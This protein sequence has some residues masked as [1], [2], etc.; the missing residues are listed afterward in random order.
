M[1]AINFSTNKTSYL[2]FY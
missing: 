1:Q 2:T